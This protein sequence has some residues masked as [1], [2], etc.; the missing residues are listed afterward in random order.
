MKTFIQILALWGGVTAHAAQQ[1]V[2]P[3]GLANVEG[4]SSGSGPFLTAGATFQQVYA[5]SEFAALGAPTG[6]ITG[7]SF[8]L[9]S[10]AGQRLLGSWP[11]L[12]ISLATTSQSPDGLSPNM[13]DNA[14]PATIVLGG[15]I[16][17]NTTYV[18]GVNPQQF[19]IRIQFSQ[20]YSYVPSQGN[21]SMTMGGV[22]GQQSVLLDGESTVGDAVGSVFGNGSTLSGTPSPFGLITR[23][24]ITPIPE[25]SAAILALM[26]FS[27]L[28][29]LARTRTRS[30]HGS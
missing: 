21:L 11:S 17:F 28:F 10:A 7:V 3:G 4:N 23:F 25:P 9:D 13:A 22:G 26:A 5:A 19:D 27:F 1:L 16:F 2:V 20:L 30:S 29:G 6:I 14:G 12:T 24:D 15:S 18:P 8:R